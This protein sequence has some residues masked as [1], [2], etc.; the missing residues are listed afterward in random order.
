VLEVEPMV[1]VLAGTALRSR[2]DPQAE[3]LAIFEADAEVPIL[4]R[5][6][7]WIRTHHQDATGWLAPGGEPTVEE[8]QLE[9]LEAGYLVVDTSP[10]ERAARIE[11]ARSLL[12]QENGKFRNLG[13]WPLYTDVEDDDE[14]TRLDRVARQ[15]REIYEGRFGLRPGDDPSRAVVLYRNEDS[16]RRFTREFTNI[17][18]LHGDGH[19]DDAM[20]ALYLDTTDEIDVA[21]IL[22]HELTHLV[23]RDVFRRPVKTWVEE[24]LAN[25]LGLS[26]IDARGNIA[27]GTLGVRNTR[28]TTSG[29][30]FVWSE[31]LRDWRE[32]RTKLNPVTDLLDF[33][34]AEFVNDRYRRSNY[35]QS[36]FLIRYLLDEGTAQS[37]RGFQDFLAGA[38]RGGPS[39]TDALTSALGTS[40]AELRSEYER[41][42]SRRALA[43]R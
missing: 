28:S 22:V 5:R 19:A 6:G 1:R 4:E 43:A 7:R 2:P 21:A 12:G 32:D 36:T 18:E 20:A 10:A 13:G 33:A 23:N 39:G 15:V 37:R 16:Y 9:A 35:A 38:S 8:F 40:A 29:G 31:L 30:Q 3:A 26:R 24:G 11:S 41:W 17:G 25:D 42:L 27:P 34:W 14:L